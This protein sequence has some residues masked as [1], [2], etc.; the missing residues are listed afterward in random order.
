[1]FRLLFRLRSNSRLRHNDWTAIV[2]RLASFP[3][4]TRWRRVPK[5]SSYRQILKQREFWTEEQNHN[6]SNAGH[7]CRHALHAFSVGRIASL[8][9]FLLRA[10]SRLL[11]FF[12]IRRARV[13][14]G[15]RLTSNLR[16]N[17]ETTRLLEE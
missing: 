15:Q 7:G 3:L 16:T 8:L 2:R 10:I 13:E 17:V 6:T 14:V 1:M 5:T 12:G 4:S 11:R 9:I